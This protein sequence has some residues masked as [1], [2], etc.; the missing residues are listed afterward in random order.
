MG[1]ALP[2]AQRPLFKRAVRYLVEVTAGNGNVGSG[3]VITRDGLILTAYHVIKGCG[4]ASIRRCRLSETTWNIVR[5]GRYA[6]DVVYK[7]V[8][9]DIAV[10]RLRKPP[11]TLG[12]APLGYS[13]ELKV[14]SGVYRVGRDDHP[15]ASGHMLVSETTDGIPS[16]EFSMESAVGASGGPIF[17]ERIRL[18]ALTT[19]TSLAKSEPAKTYGLPI[20]WIRKRVLKHKSVRELLPEDFFTR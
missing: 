6:A 15:L 3:V 14:G 8:R 9:A 13:K 1:T 12:V 20:D 19:E 7:N 18:V 4:E 16:C 10:L 2:E 11:K 5:F 17:N